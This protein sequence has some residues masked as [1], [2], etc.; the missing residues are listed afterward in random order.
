MGFISDLFK[1]GK[2]KILVVDDDPSVRGLVQ[3]LL[4]AEGYLVE[5]AE[6]GILG[7]AKFKSGSYDLLIL[8]EH[9]PRMDGTALLNLIRSS[10][11]GAG[12]KVLMLSGETMLDPINRAYQH[13]IVDWIPK[14]FAVD[15]LLKKVIA[16]LGAP[17]K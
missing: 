16:H 14:P 15:A 5:T 4:S 6:D 1:P 12:Q 8:D 13:G 10:P 9:M 11:K 7:L 2:K 17:K 3:D